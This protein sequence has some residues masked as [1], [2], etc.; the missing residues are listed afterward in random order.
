M[1]L[2]VGETI[3]ELFESVLFLKITKYP[4]MLEVWFTP[5]L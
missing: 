3:P 1:G 5:E 4:N 2:N